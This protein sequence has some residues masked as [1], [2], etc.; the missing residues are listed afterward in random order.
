M[1]KGLTGEQMQRGSQIKAVQQ[2]K[3]DS[4]LLS[5]K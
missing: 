5:S 2:R 4:D 3:E 1:E